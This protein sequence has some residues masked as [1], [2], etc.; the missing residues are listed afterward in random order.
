MHLK[1][2][3]SVVTYLEYLMLGKRLVETFAICFNLKDFLIKD[4][5]GFLYNLKLLSSMTLFEAMSDSNSKF[6][7]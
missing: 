1:A 5:T 2:L 4:V 6:I 3:R 7:K